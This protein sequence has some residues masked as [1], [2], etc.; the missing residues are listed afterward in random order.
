MDTIFTT[1]TDTVDTIFTINADTVGT[2]FT[3][4]EDTV[5]TIGS[6]IYKPFKFCPHSSI[7]YVFMFVL[8]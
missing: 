3:I 7:W 6:D 8:L 5:G 1:D 4:D 2:I